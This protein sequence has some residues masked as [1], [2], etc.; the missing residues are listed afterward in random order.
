MSARLIEKTHLSAK[1]LLEKVREVF[2]KVKEPLRGGQGKKKEI[3]VTDCLMSALAMFKMKFPSMLQFDKHKN[4]EPIKQNIKN[5]FGVEKVPCDTYT[6]EQL[7]EVDPSA[8]RPAFTAL[9]STLQRGKVLEKYVFLD[10]KCLM[11]SD[12]TGYYS[13]HEIH[14]ENCCKKEHRNGS[15]T[16][17]HQLLGA[18]IA[19]PDHKEVIPICPEPIM[20][21]DGSKKNDCERNATERLLRDFRREHPH[22]LVILVEDALASNGPHIKLLKELGISFITVVK[23]DGNK[24][25]FD[26]IEAFDWEKIDPKSSY[27][28]YSFEDQNGKIHT[29]RFANQVPLND[30]HHDLKVNFIEYWEFDKNGKQLY[31]NTWVTDTEVTTENI[32]QITKGGRTRWKVENETFNT[33]KNQGYHLEHNYGH[34]N[35]NL[36]TIF[37]MLMMLAFLID[38]TEQ[39]CCGLFQA[40]L[41]K[42]HSTKKYL[43]ERIRAFFTTYIIPSW[44]ILYRAIISGDLRDIPF[45]N[46]G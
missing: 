18:V 45:L 28:K 43:W 16:Y 14:C 11:L 38:Q 10:G 32:Y 6:R 40:A 26:W 8:I 19:H 9:F 39:L 17:Y 1:G 36:S 20:K 25:L 29:F 3:T 12:G 31:H 15:V 42:M 27:G 24:F 34:G 7:D 13:S 46:S 33:L 44:E 37:A 35:K 5:L 30:S 22:L 21:S 41:K 2:K 23:P 4:D